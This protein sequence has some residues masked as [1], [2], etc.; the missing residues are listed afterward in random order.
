MRSY[1]G[2]YTV[3]GTQIIESEDLKRITD[4]LENKLT[5]MTSDPN[6]WETLYYCVEDRS[7][8]L[9]SHEYP[10]MHGGGVKVLNEIEKE[11]AESFQQRFSGS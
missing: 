7:Y 6:S 8:W 11:Q 5:R 10:E 9:L 4:M 1:H 3:R 2:T